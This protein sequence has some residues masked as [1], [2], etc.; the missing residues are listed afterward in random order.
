MTVIAIGARDRRRDGLNLFLLM[1]RVLVGQLGS[2]IAFIGT[3]SWLH[4][5][6]ASA[7]LLG[8]IA[9]VTALPLLLLGPIG[10]VM[11]DRCDRRRLLMVTDAAC[12]VLSIG[13]VGATCGGLPHSA[14]ISLAFACNILLSAVSAFANP[15]MSAIV[16][17]LVHPGLV[18]RALS[19]T[20]SCSLVAML[21]GQVLGALLIDHLP[22]A[23]LFVFEAVTYLLGFGAT[24]LTR[25]RS[26][27]EKASADAN[28]PKG[29]LRPLIAGW[30][31]VQHDRGMMWLLCGAVPISLFIEPLP[32]FLPFYVTN[33][34]DLPVSR[35]PLLL[36]LFSLGLIAGYVQN[37]IHP[38]RGARRRVMVLSGT[39]AAGAAMAGLAM[40]PNMWCA[41]VA[42]VVL[43]LLYGIVATN[44]VNALL[45]NVASEQR[46]RLMALAMM[47]TQ[48]LPPLAMPLFGRAADFVGQDMRGL[49][50]LCSAGLTMSGLMLTLS[51]DLRRFLSETKYD[52]LSN[53]ECD[54]E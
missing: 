41:A 43:G 26:H 49:Y 7:S 27:P 33:G 37:A 11:S 6:G 34:L 31:Y 2:Q 54:H 1:Q 29:L 30:R 42:I 39:P 3:L 51:P 16:P 12:L 36:A 8:M 28:V 24:Y 5:Q 23:V 52:N 17:D 35:Y 21:V 18:D 40:A 10:G 48:G 38:A 9:T 14:A 46:G 32:I 19:A 53:Q 47:L 50:L 13:L 20:Q 44:A 22:I 25:V 15:G 45:G 4:E